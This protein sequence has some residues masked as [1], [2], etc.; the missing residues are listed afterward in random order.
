MRKLIS[1]LQPPFSTV[2]RYEVAACLLVTS[3]LTSQ[4][5]WRRDRL[6]AFTADH[7]K[8]TPER[9]LRVTQLADM[10]YELRDQPCIDEVVRRARTRDLERTF[11]ELRVA[12]HLHRHGLEVH[13]RPEKNVKGQDFDF[14]VKSNRGQAAVE[15]TGLTAP[16]F[17]LSSVV[18]RLK[19][20]RKQLPEDMPGLL[21][22]FVPSAWDP[23]T[24]DS[25]LQK[26]AAEFMRQTQRVN[27][28]L[29]IQ[30]RIR[31]VSRSVGE[32]NFFTTHAENLMARYPARWLSEALNPPVVMNV[33]A[34]L[35]YTI[36]THGRRPGDFYDWVDSMLNTPFPSNPE[37]LEVALD[38][39]EPEGSI[40]NPGFSCAGD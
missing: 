37:A 17:K 23:N 15:A 14:I 38:E 19:H 29:L 7:D 28:L 35:D 3:V 2:R 8:M 33:G 10:L 26:V 11:F 32:V 12:R 18:E 25:N 5:K 16:E 20:K 36:E 9:M 24:T 22:A 30:E 34:P 31:M 40:R 39:D 4:I 27:H 13:A 1:E 6:L 21:M